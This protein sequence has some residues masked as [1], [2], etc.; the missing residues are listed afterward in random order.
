MDWTDWIEQLHEQ[1]RLNGTRWFWMT[2][3]PTTSIYNDVVSWKERNLD[4]ARLTDHDY[5]AK[6]SPVTARIVKSAIYETLDQIDPRFSKNHPERSGQHAR[7][8]VILVPALKVRALGNGRLIRV[9]HYHGWIV[10]HPPSRETTSDPRTYATTTL[11][12]RHDETPHTLYVPEPV[13]I[14][15]N[16]LMDVCGSNLNV[17]TP[18]SDELLRTHAIYATRGATNDTDGIASRI[19]RET[20]YPTS[21]ITMPHWYWKLCFDRIVTVA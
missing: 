11:T 21:T 14:F 16:R 19:N 2:L 18:D 17:T 20:N 7:L 10:L 1:D 8:A 13:A 3:T 15:G 6:T 5:V 9:L 12:V 4:H